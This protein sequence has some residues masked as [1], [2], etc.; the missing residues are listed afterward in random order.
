MPTAVLLNPADYAALDIAVFNANATGPTV[1][2]TFWGLDVISSSAK[3]AGGAIVGDF[4]SAIHHYYRSAISLYIT[5]SHADTFL[6]NVFTL[7]AERRSKTVVVRPQ[8]LVET[9]AA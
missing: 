9:K 4:R 6:S 8:A 2:Q 3:A 5:D 1:G 7:L